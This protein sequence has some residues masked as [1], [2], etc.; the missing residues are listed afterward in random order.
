MGFPNTVLE[1]GQ[2]SRGLPIRACGGYDLA[3]VNRP[4]T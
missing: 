4:V 3:V 1:R 2:S